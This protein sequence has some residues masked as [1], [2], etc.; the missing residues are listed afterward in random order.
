[1]AR[2]SFSSAYL[3]HEQRSRYLAE[4]DRQRPQTR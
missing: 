2:N 4:L 1:M 3:S